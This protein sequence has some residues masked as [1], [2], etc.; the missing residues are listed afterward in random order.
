[1]S[2]S[3]TLERGVFLSS[4]SHLLLAVLA[5]LALTAQA[6]RGGLPAQYRSKAQGPGLIS[7]AMNYYATE[8]AARSH[9]EAVFEQVEL[10]K[11]YRTD[12]EK[13]AAVDRVMADLRKAPVSSSW[14]IAEIRKAKTTHSVRALNKEITQQLFKK[15]NVGQHGILSQ[16]N[17]SYWENEMLSSFNDCVAGGEPIQECQ[18]EYQKSMPKKIGRAVV[19]MTAFEDLNSKKDVTN[20][21][22]YIDAA[23]YKYN[24]CIAQ[25][26]GKKDLPV[27]SCA[28]KA[29]FSTIEELVE[30]EIAIAKKK[31]KIEN[32]EAFKKL[33]KDVL[34]RLSSCLNGISEEAKN[35]KEL[36]QG[37]GNLAKKNA[38]VMI[39]SHQYNTNPALQ[40][41]VPK[42]FDRKKHAD[43]LK[44]EVEKC[45]SGDS[46]SLNGE[47]CAISEGDKI[48]KAAA[49]EIS[50]LTI[51]EKLES[52]L[53]SRNLNGKLT[54]EEQTD[55]DA[56]VRSYQQEFAQCIG[57][58]NDEASFKDCTEGDFKKLKAAQ[59]ERDLA[60]QI[61]GP[62]AKATV[63]EKLKSH[64]VPA[65]HDKLLS[66]LSQCLNRRKDSANAQ[67]IA[68]DTKNCTGAYETSVAG[69]IAE[70][71]LKH[72][73]AEALGKKGLEENKGKLDQVRLDFEKCYSLPAKASEK[74]EQKEERCAQ[75]VHAG[76]AKIAREVLEKKLISKGDSAQAK[77][78]KKKLAQVF[79]DAGQG[80]GAG[81]PS[82]DIVDANEKIAD[83][84]GTLNNPEVTRALGEYVSYNPAAAN[85]QIG[86]ME[87]SLKGGTLGGDTK[88]RLY[89]AMDESG[90]NDQLVKSKIRADVMKELNSAKGSIGVPSKVVSSLTSNSNFDKI[91]TKEVLRKLDAKNKVLKPMF[92]GGKGSDKASLAANNK[93]LRMEVAKVLADSEHF[94]AMIA[95]HRIQGGI[96]EMDGAKKFM[97]NLFLGP[98][99]TNWDKQR[100]KPMGKK[101]EDFIQS[102]II[103]PKMNGEWNKLSAKEKQR[104]FAQ[105]EAHVQATIT[106]SNLVA[107]EGTGKRRAPAN[108]N[109]I[110]RQALGVQ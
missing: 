105:V 16:R 45:F 10:K 12:A 39:A 4:L 8:Y 48:K 19:S 51:R 89:K 63:K 77:A 60:G 59:A 7:N 55:I 71:R 83:G 99:A 34:A 58:S 92:L 14:S 67:E 54:A 108:T 65:E 106:N 40:A 36:A 82:V 29:L 57:K 104:R 61:A 66:K 109:D 101:T 68:L 6:G 78:A 56:I 73:L 81:S 88:E 38:A 50:S 80:S 52:E 46:A 74:K 69:M 94:G 86:E 17:A 1:M 62:A 20:K 5:S 22:D 96:N 11:Y 26:G 15:Q 3:D 98:N 33:E 93:A 97:A 27:D 35:T 31:Q 30:D 107:S 25:A 47:A 21:K 53:S 87:S 43:L 44:Q 102:Q 37:C 42:D 90:A 9:I 84:Y 75:I 18:V 49:T 91:F 110:T 23:D 64:G 2:Y 103:L 72:A 28:R 41:N 13:K 85:R 24:L 95:K 76:G 100:L 79:V 32:S 70:A